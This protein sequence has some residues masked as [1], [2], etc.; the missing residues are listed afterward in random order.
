[1]ANGDQILT[2]FFAAPNEKPKGRCLLR[3]DGYFTALGIGPNLIMPGT[4]LKH[5]LEDRPPMKDL[6]EANLV[7]AALME[8]YNKIIK[9]LHGP[10]SKYRPS[11]VPSDR[12]KAP[13]LERA[14]AWCEGFVEGMVLDTGWAAMYEDDAKH[15]F[16]LPITLYAPSWHEDDEREEATREQV[17]RLPALWNIPSSTYFHDQ[18]K[19]KGTS[20]AFAC[21]KRAVNKKRDATIFVP[22]DQ[23]ENI[24]AA[25]A[26]PKTCSPFNWS[27]STSAVVN[28]RLL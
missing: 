18:R 1:M 7:T 14:I 2:S 3:L 13:S 15:T 12:M 24:N 25:A 19:S 4:W 27:R 28:P 22:A 8:R 9:S 21:L 26:Q 5:L 16:L 20:G 6:T 10:P 11:C 23:E 17:E